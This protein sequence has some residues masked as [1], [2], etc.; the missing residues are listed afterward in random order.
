MSKV[1]QESKIIG[2]RVFKKW[3]GT[4]AEMAETAAVLMPVITSPS[5]TC[6]LGTCHGWPDRL[7]V[8]RQTVSLLKTTCCM[9]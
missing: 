5:I 8:S 4:L 1:E 7:K 2:L 9:F 3:A 6:R